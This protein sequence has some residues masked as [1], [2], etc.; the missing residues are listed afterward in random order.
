[1]FGRSVVGCAHNTWQCRVTL[2]PLSCVLA[3][4]QSKGMRFLSGFQLGNPLKFTCAGTHKHIHAHTSMHAHIFTHQ[5]SFR[6]TL[7][8]ACWLCV[9]VCVLSS[10]P[11]RCPHP[12]TPSPH[13]AGGGQRAAPAATHGAPQDTPARGCDA[14]VGGRHPQRVRACVHACRLHNL[15]SGA[16]AAWACRGGPMCFPWDID[17]GMARLCIRTCPVPFPPMRPVHAPTCAHA[18]LHAGRGHWN[19]LRAWWAWPAPCLMTP[20]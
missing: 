13:R 7:T 4:D 20:G 3:V 2:L 8:V 11:P 17:N 18:P 1:M 6:R 12:F 10:C 15:S 16:H 19:S 9:C 14:G 5:L